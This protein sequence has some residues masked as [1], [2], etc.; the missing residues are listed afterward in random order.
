M[1]SFAQGETKLEAARTH[2]LFAFASCGLSIYFSALF[3]SPRLV[4][5]HPTEAESQAGRSPPPPSAGSIVLLVLV[6]I[7]RGH[8][9]R[10]D[11]WSPRPRPSHRPSRLR[12]YHQ[13]RALSDG[14]KET[15]VSAHRS[16]PNLL[17][18]PA[19]LAPRLF[20]A[21][22]FLPIRAFALSFLTL[23][24]IRATSALPS[25]PR[26]LPLPIAPDIVVLC[27]GHRFLSDLSWWVRREARLAC[28]TP[29]VL[30]TQDRGVTIWMEMG[31]T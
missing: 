15:S 20:F 27:S 9:V 29:G 18:T 5:R 22:S 19:T 26:P 13:H 28:R 30:G 24:L 31:V 16:I 17:E 1:C 4:P 14:P 8:R 23:E 3:P 11:R 10:D 6:L 12:K 2:D 21:L 7:L 25:P